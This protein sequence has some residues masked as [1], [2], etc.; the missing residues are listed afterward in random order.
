MKKFF[1]LNKGILAAVV[2]CG[3]VMFAACSKDADDSVQDAPVEV[4]ELNLGGVTDDGCT[5]GDGNADESSDGTGDEPVSDNGMGS[6]E[7]PYVP[8]DGQTYVVA[9]K[10][11]QNMI[12]HMV[13][14]YG[15]Y[16][17]KSDDT[18]NDLLTKMEQKDPVAADRWGRI[19]ELWR[20]TDNDLELNYDVLPDGL[21]D[22]D[23]LCLVVLGFQLKADG[24]MKD[25]L[26]QRLKVALAS[27]EK[28]PNSY[29]LCTGGGTAA[30]NASAT[31]AGEM[32]KWLIENGISSDRVIVENR[33]RTTPENAI[34]SYEILRRDYPQVN[35][36]AI[37][38][39]D[40]HIAT[41]VLLFGAETILGAGEDGKEKIEVVSNAAWSAPSGYLADWFKAGSLV[42]ISGDSE[43]AYAIYYSG[44]G[45]NDL[46]PIKE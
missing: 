29:I 25:E 7:A 2:L 18:V 3:T 26:I 6:M 27:A 43:T 12:N 42:E 40:Y 13:M 34:F 10:D 11:V 17:A 1:L 9:D 45:V 44:Y 33:S 37:V 46:P 19:M 24:T 30:G 36:I 15:A 41:G 21:K 16:G 23:E 20:T 4:V 22:T 39:S 5:S 31:E 28:Y 35:Q 8:D 14:N 32:A 38:S